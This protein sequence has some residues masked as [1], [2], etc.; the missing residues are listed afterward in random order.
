[1]SVINGPEV[2]NGLMVGE[3]STWRDAALLW[4]WPVGGGALSCLVVSDAV[5]LCKRAA[6]DASGVMWWCPVILDERLT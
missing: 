4:R 1:M 5:K 3:E 2:L 6:E